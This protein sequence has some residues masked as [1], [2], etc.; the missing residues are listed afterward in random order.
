M[1]DLAPNNPYGLTLRS[2]VLVAA[3][4]VGYGV[5]YTRLLDL[6]A[7]GALVTRTTTLTPRRAHQ[8]R[9]QMIETPAGLLYVGGW[10]NPG[11]AHVL[12]RLAPQ[13]AAW[14]VPVILSA[15]G[16]TLGEYRQIAEAL[17]GVE[18]IAGLELSVHAETAA[19]ATAAARSATQ[20][21]LLVKLP[22]LDPQPLLGLAHEVVAAGA[23]ALTIAAP[24]RGLH[25]DPIS[26]A[27]HEGWLC[28]PA[29]LPLTLQHVAAIA[30]VVGVPVVGCGGLASADHVRQCLA[31]GATATQLGS[32][33]L[34]NPFAAAELSSLFPDP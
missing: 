17:E 1:F 34:V 20:L 24:P 3:G 23:D 11:L 33:L 9:P 14:E 5:E 31:A 2:P 27:Q 29:L 15:A 19:L 25:L 13:W 4:C 21:P 8:H 22:A 16:E 32:A 6:A 28:G 18:G 7:F 10:P 26:G 12:E 30:S